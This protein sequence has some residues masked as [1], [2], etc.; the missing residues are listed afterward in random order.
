MAS[1][2]HTGICLLIAT[3]FGLVVSKIEDLAIQAFHQLGLP[4]DVQLPTVLSTFVR[5]LVRRGRTPQAMFA[6]KNRL[7][8]ASSWLRHM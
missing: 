2:A 7:N 4:L 1:I 3:W 6:H 5:V 8:T